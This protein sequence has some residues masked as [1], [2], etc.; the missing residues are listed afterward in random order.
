[1]KIFELKGDPLIVQWLD[2]ITSPATKNNYLLGLQT[3]TE[4]VCKTPDELLTEAEQEATTL[5]RKRKITTYL[6]GFKKYLQEKELAPLSQKNYL[7]GVKSFYQFN[8]IE[9]PKLK[10]EKAKPLKKN[11]AI[12]TKEDIQ[13]TLK[14]CDHLERAIILVGVSSGL[15]ANEIINLKIKDFKEGY[16]SVTEI[17]TLDLRRQKATVDF[18]TFF[19]PETSRAI[20]E[21]LNY[22]ART[23]KTG[24]TKRLNQL[25]KQRVFS[26]SG[27]LFI[28]RK[29]SDDFLKDR[30]EE[31]RKLNREAFMKIFRD[32]SE[33]AQ[34]NTI[35][36]DWNLIRSHNI[37]K[38]FN[39]ALL[40]AGADFFHVELFMGHTLPSTQEH[41]FR[42]S[43][44]KL[45][46]I[47]KKYIP[48]LTIQKE[49]DISES[50]EYLAIKK[51]NEILR[52][53]TERH[54]VTRH[55]FQDIRNAINSLVV[56]T[57]PLSPDATKE[58]KERHANRKR[59]EERA[60]ALQ[61]N[62]KK[63]FHID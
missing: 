24:E 10:S 28:L 15:S 20:K 46:E 57:P 60:T 22:R 12:P 3:F 16:D 62:M 47:Y 2:T 6:I 52:A 5:M 54:V 50:P 61:D 31:K 34:K 53:E 45:K 48:Y 41:Y 30:D 36:G 33:K 37:R 59:L 8:Y 56:Q 39:S 44:E 26:D 35:K 49:L 18:I 29:V 11:N 27:Y 9:L 40:N 7:T 19:T 38:Y 51:E 13:D 63:I 14:V 4:W 55:D 58:E 17:T 25:E 23:V 32:I 43:P 21:Y 42:A 1:M